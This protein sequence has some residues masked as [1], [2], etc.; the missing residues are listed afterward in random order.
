MRTVAGIQKCMHL[1]MRNCQP[2]EPT[3]LQIHRGF[4]MRESNIQATRIQ[5]RVEPRRVTPER[6]A[7]AEAG[8]RPDHPSAYLSRRSPVQR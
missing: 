5:H 7:E 2:V 1:R 4:A 3:R 8:A 6:C